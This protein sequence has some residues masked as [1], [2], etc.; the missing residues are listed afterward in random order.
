MKKKTIYN[1]IKYGLL[2]TFPSQH[3]KFFIDNESMSIE[4]LNYLSSGNSLY[5]QIEINKDDSI[6]L[7]IFRSRDTGDDLPVFDC[8]WNSVSK[9]LEDKDIDDY[10]KDLVNEEENKKEGL[11]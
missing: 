6:Y 11:A 3:P 5:G 1:K 4:Y 7:W 9:F 8:T 10:I 2:T